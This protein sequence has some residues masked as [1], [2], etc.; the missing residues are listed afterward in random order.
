MS[1][2]CLL[3]RL[4]ETKYQVRLWVCL[5][6]LIFLSAKLDRRIVISLNVARLSEV[7]Q[8][9]IYLLMC[10]YVVFF[11]L[12]ESNELFLCSSGD[13]IR[14]SHVC[15]GITECPD[16]SDEAQCQDSKSC[17]RYMQR[18]PIS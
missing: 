1:G 9:S 11:Q 14:K 18:G 8:L 2:H 15:N 3:N 16:G 17:S 7:L 4:K 13:F 10:S 5:H 12:K 6:I